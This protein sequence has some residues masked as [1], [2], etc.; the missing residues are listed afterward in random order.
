MFNSNQQ[1]TIPPQ[2]AGWRTSLNNSQSKHLTSQ[3]EIRNPKSAIKGFTLIELLVVVAIIAVLVSILLPA[4]GRAR[5]SARLA[6]CSSHLKQVF[7]MIHRYAEDFNGY[8]PL[9]S[10]RRP[11]GTW[12][13]WRYTM[14][15]LGYR[16][17]W[18]SE[19]YNCP[20]QASYKG[21]AKTVAYGLNYYITYNQWFHGAKLRR[22]TD[23]EWPSYTSLSGDRDGSVYVYTTWNCFSERNYW[24]IHGGQQ[25]VNVLYIDG[26]VSSRL[27]SDIPA[28]TTNIFWYG[29]SRHD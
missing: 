21:V 20:S 12:Q 2:S 24:A 26:H 5:E 4:L 11:N 8:L 7:F 3:S 22:I 10:F 9:N 14:Q 1:S 16:Q 29:N 23:I 27:G 19:I 15:V 6:I 28:D 13:D 17:H 18:D 25:F